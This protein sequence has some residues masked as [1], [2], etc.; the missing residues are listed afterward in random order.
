MSDSLFL[1]SLS[2]FFEKLCNDFVF[3]CLIIAKIK[4]KVK[5]GACL[6]DAFLI[7][8]WG[9]RYAP[10][11]IKKPPV[12]CRNRGGRNIGVKFIRNYEMLLR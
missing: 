4:A 10:P 2:S 5:T 6:T 3:K 8:F 12:S 11:G 1:M 9:G 7:P